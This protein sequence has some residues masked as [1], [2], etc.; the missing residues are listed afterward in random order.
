M[1]SMPELQ[2]PA[3]A[4][5]EEWAASP[6]LYAISTWELSRSSI[7]RWPQIPEQPCSRLSYG[8]NKCLLDY[9]EPLRQRQ[10]PD[11]SLMILRP[12]LGPAL[13]RIAF[14]RLTC[15][16]AHSFSL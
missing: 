2:V 3:F 7:L 8:I 9:S 1:R 11:A 13:R 10:R 6:L 12:H 14:Y 5:W 15:N 4:D 16:S